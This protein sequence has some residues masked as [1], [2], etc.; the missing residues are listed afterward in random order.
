LITDQ[1]QKNYTGIPYLARI[2]VLGA[3][4]RG[5]TA[6]HQRT[7]LI[8]LM[9]PQVTL[10]KLDFYRLRQKWENYTH[11]GPEI[12]QPDCA[13]CPKTETGKQLSLPPPDI[14]PAKD[15]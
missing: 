6:S 13:D 7:E 4:F 8:V 5:T 9:C 3:L 12:D 1:K 10:T 15:M 2:P 11:Y 14:P